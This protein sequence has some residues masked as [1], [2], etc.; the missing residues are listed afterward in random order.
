MSSHR[1][2][3]FDPAAEKYVS[4]ATYRRNGIAVATPVWIAP[5]AGRHYVF[6][7]GDAGKVKRI[8][9]NP[10][11][12][13]AACNFRGELRS[14]WL[15]GRARVLTEPAAMEQARLALRAKYGLSMWFADVG[16]RLSGRMRRRAYIEIEMSTPP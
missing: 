9:A 5:H 1:A 11:V 8:R 3:A 12:R 16:A 4:L 6:S 13:L 15:H 14:D 2:I 7:A 10:E